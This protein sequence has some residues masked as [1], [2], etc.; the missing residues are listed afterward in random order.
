MMSTGQ[1]LPQNEDMLHMN[2]QSSVD[3][4]N[5]IGGSDTNNL[6]RHSSQGKINQMK[7]QIQTQLEL[8]KDRVTSEI[9]LQMPSSP[10]LQQHQV[11]APKNYESEKNLL[12]SSK[13]K[14]Q[15]Q[16]NTS[17]Q[18]LDSGL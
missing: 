6:S 15:Q 9:D 11:S 4:E 16:V 1:A 12:S 13:K 8:E 18:I 5:Q 14:M 7:L 10:G 17:N 2:G 3:D